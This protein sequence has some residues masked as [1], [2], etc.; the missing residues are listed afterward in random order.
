MELLIC[1]S[2]RQW[3]TTGTLEWMFRDAAISRNFTNNRLHPE[4]QVR[5]H[6][7]CFMMAESDTNAGPLMSL[8]STGKTSSFANILLLI[9]MG[10]ALLI[11]NQYVRWSN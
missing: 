7:A 8:Y 9:G 1:L 4:L 10:R 6:I 5:S 3:T 2:Q 11:M